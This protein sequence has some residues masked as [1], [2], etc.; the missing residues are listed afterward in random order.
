MPSK[1]AKKRRETLAR[2][3]AGRTP[4]YNRWLYERRALRFED[5]MRFRDA[6]ERALGKPR[7]ADAQS[8]LRAALEKADARARE[9]GNRYDHKNDHPFWEDDEASA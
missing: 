4:A 5:A 7:P 3:R 1:D 2:W 8:I 9:V 6:I